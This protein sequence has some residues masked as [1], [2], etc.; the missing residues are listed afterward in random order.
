MN[1]W[2]TLTKPGLW[3]HPLWQLTYT[4]F[5]EFARNNVGFIIMPLMLMMGL[6]MA[7]GG[8]KQPEVRVT[9][10]EAPGAEALAN[11]LT[12]LGGFEVTRA[13]LAEGEERLGKGRANLVLV[14]GS[15]PELVGDPT[16]PEHRLARLAVMDALRRME[17]GEPR[18]ETRERTVEKP[19]KR[20]V[21]FLVPG[22][23][24][25][26]LLGPAFNGVAGVLVEHRSR[27]LLKGYAATPMKRHHF[28]FGVAFSRLAVSLLAVP[29]IAVA[30]WGVFDVKIQGPLTSFV[31]FALGGMVMLCGLG[32]VAG[33]RARTTEQLNPIYTFVVPLQMLLCGIFFSTERLPEVVQAVVRYL[34]LTAYADGLRLIMNDGVSLLGVVP[35][36]LV[37]GAWGVATTAIALKSF[38]WQ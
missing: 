23:L 38:A 6:G 5:L 32:F 9:V 21:D 34:P 36:M 3:S 17:G 35:Q 27:K 26:T 29:V 20:Y 22:V 12:E 8:Q 10:V 13:T 19:G 4:E 1:R 25:F 11:K 15:P 2:Q 24:A 28:L 18:L 14:P 33:C 31:L 16:Q 30:G 37:L 7:F